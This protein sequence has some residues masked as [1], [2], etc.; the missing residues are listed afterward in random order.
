MRGLSWHIASWKWL[1][2]ILLLKGL[3]FTYFAWE[4]H[5]L[6]GDKLI[7]GIFRVYDDTRSYYDPIENLVDGK[8]YSR[9]GYAEY[10]EQEL[11]PFAGRLPGLLPV[12]GPLYAVLG[13]KAARAVMVLL[14]FLMGCLGVWLMGQI[15]FRLLKSQTMAFIVMFLYLIYYPLHIYEHA[16]ASESL[17]MFFCL[18]S[19]GF[20]LK[21]AEKDAWKWLVWA[22]IFFAWAVFLRPVFGSLLVAFAL[23]LIGTERRSAGEKKG[24]YWNL[25][26]I[27]I[28]FLPLLIALSVWS[29]RNSLTMNRFIPLEDAWHL[30]Y[31]HEPEYRPGGMAIRKLIRAWGGDM[32]YWTH[33]SMG[34]MLMNPKTDGDIAKDLPKRVY[35][36]DYQADSIQL[37]RDFYLEGKQEKAASMAVRFLASYQQH[38]PLEAYFFSRIRLTVKF[39]FRLIRHDLPFPSRENIQPYQLLIK[40]FYILYYYFWAVLGLLGGIYAW[41]KKNTSQLKKWLLFPLSMTFVL[42]FVLGMIEERY[43]LPLFPFMLIYGVYLLFQWPFMR[44]IIPLSVNS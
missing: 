20:L 27:S 32:L 33:G 42:T 1:I 25:K 3:L 6:E 15:A 14:Q 8:G 43:L 26:I 5:R 29:T 30:S 11:V 12:Y 16:G 18:L 38:K 9:Y 10:G 13:Q 21:Y 37:L 35:T 31:P 34:N 41:G 24:L 44:K 4:L 40:G 36:P 19:F 39:F 17:S 2:P 28:F 23:V 22:G 7:A